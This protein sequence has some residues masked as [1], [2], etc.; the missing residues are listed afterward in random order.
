MEAHGE[1][2][3]GIGI[4]IDPIADV[5]KHHD[6]VIGNAMSFDADVSFRQPIG[7]GPI[8]HVAEHPHVKRLGEVVGEEVLVLLPAPTS[9]CRAFD[10]VF[11]FRLVEI[12]AA[13]DPALLETGPF[14]GLKGRRVVGFLEEISHGLPTDRDP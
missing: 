8:P 9:P 3:W 13:G 2:V 6:D 1:F 12:A 7:T 5:I 14:F 11:L 10:D 4:V